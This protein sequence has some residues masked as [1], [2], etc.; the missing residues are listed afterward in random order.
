MLLHS[1]GRTLD[2]G[3][4]H[5]DVIIMNVTLEFPQLLLLDGLNHDRRRRRSYTQAGGSLG[6]LEDRWIWAE[7][8]GVLNFR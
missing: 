8:L 6:G 3:L 7:F 1:T 2:T 4:N 5:L